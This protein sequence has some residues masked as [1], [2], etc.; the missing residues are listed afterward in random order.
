MAYSISEYPTGV[1]LVLSITLA[2]MSHVV[3]HVHA[4]HAALLLGIGLDDLAA[5]DGFFMV[6]S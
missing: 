6:C 2:A 1:L 5:L 3:W 4:A